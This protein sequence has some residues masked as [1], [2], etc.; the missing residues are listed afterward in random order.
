MAIRKFK[1]LFSGNNLDY[2]WI[3]SSERNNDPDHSPISESRNNDPDHSPLSEV[4][5]MTRIIVLCDEI[6]VMAESAG[7]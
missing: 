1:N 5:I 7:E 4:G 6:F 3:R 2:T